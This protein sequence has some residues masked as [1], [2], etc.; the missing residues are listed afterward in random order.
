MD[1]LV[2]HDCVTCNKIFSNQDLL[3]QHAVEC[4]ATVNENEFPCGD[5]ETVLK[6]SDILKEHQYF[7][8]QTLFECPISTCKV[9]LNGFLI[10][11][12]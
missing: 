7:K 2:F 3:A 5:C 10:T 4:D 8:H 1:Y 12:F 6:T 11:L 9:F